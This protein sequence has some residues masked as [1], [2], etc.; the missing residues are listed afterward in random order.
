MR[1]KRWLENNSKISEAAGCVIFAKSTGRI[2]LQQRSKRTSHPLVWGCWGGGMEKKETPKETV[3]RELKEEAG[4]TGDIKL[5]SLSTFVNNNFRY[6]SFLGLIGE[7][8]EPKLNHESE[9][10]IWTT[11]DKLPS[12]LHPGLKWLLSTDKNKI[13][14]I[15]KEENKK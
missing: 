5:I 13:N 11:L 14:N 8:F 15:L 12:P 10:Y 2:L 1:F 7:E 4:F 9:D 6:Y 3:K